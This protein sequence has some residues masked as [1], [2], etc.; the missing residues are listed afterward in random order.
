MGLADGI[1]L[2]ETH[3][4]SIVVVAGTFTTIAAGKRDV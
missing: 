4:L 3:T 1:V 2:E